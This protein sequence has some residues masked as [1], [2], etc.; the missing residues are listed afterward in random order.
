MYSRNSKW[1]PPASTQITLVHSGPSRYILVIPVGTENYMAISS[2]EDL[3]WRNKRGGQGEECPLTFFTG[4][5]FA[6]LPGK[7]GQG[8]KRGTRKKRQKKEN[9]KGKTWKNEKF[10]R[11]MW[12]IEDA[13]ENV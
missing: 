9:L 5:F 2:G 4:N 12:K 8:G 11:E 6:D 13:S 7:D 1:H 10:E 3:Q